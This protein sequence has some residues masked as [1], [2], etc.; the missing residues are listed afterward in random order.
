L[1]V[2]FW[3]L[4]AFPI[5]GFFSRDELLIFDPRR[6]LEFLAMARSEAFAMLY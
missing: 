1:G 2:G 3:L 5:R 4:F 6:T